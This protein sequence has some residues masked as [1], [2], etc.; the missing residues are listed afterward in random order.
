MVYIYVLKL[1][2][3]K[4]YVGKTLN[5]YFRIETHFNSEGSEWT[6]LYK[7]VKILEIIKGDDYDEDKYTKIY[8]DKYG[9]DNVRGGSYTSIKLDS[10]TKNQLIKISNSNNNK[11]FKCGIKG[12]FA[13]DCNNY[14]SSNESEENEIW[15]CEYCDKEFEDE[16]KCEKHEKYCKN[17]NK[18]KS[19]SGNCCFKCGKYG[20][21]AYNCWS[22][23]SSYS[24]KCNICG[25]YGHNEVNCYELG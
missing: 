21:F 4:Y 22:N 12:H 3:A 24:K 17:K 14:N 15:C 25:K 9:I 1:Q 19:Y 8:M 20:H 16:E 5:P 2:N 23:K 18:N 7:P 6:K 13:K 11:C 10:E